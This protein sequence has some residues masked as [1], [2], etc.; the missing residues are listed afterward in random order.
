MLEKGMN[1][2]ERFWCKVKKSDSCWIWQGAKIKS[3]AGYGVIRVLGKNKLAHR[4]SY[5][6]N[7][8]AIVGNLWVLHKCDTPS[9][10]NPN[11]LF[12]GTRSDNIRDMYSKGRGNRPNKHKTH[13]P[14]NHKY[15]KENTYLYKEERHCK[16]CK[17]ENQRI[18]RK[19]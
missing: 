12:L 7:V 16:K 14:K 1:T 9:C 17:I 6:I 15:S 18:R 4:L 13:C 3:D 10:V 19:A 8:G 5:E 2:A 11:H